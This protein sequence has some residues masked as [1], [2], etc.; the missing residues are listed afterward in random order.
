MRKMILLAAM[1]AI[2]ALMLAA[3]PALAQQGNLPA[4]RE[5]DGFLIKPGDCGIGEQRFGGEQ[6]SREQ[7]LAL[8]GVNEGNLPGGVGTPKFCVIRQQPNQNNNNNNNNN[9]RFCDRFD[10]D[11]N[12][13]V[14]GPEITQTNEQEV[15]SG[16]ATQNINV[17]GGGDNSNQ[18]VGVQGVTN[19]G[20]ATNNTGVI[21]ASTPFFD[22]FNNGRNDFCDFHNCNRN[23]FCDQFDINNCNRFFHDDGF[24]RDGF[25]GFNTGGEV[26]VQDTGNLTISPSQTV[27]GNQQVNQA[28]AASAFKPWWQR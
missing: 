26:E 12:N 24:F 17:T 2:A 10:F 15:E 14:F 4:F 8:R 5:V 21:Q 18:T 28:A 22:G 23:D 19:T 3:T 27:T 7:T 11:C 16:D 25:N 20:N 13:F 6:L 9:N 1:A